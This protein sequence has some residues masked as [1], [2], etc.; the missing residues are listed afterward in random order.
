MIGCSNFLVQYAV[1]SLCYRFLPISIDA[2]RVQVA[3][4]CGFVISVLN[5]FYWNNRLVF[6]T[7][8]TKK[9]IVVSLF[10]TY[11]TYAFTGLLLNAALLYLEVDVLKISAYVA[12]FINLLITTPINFFMNKLWAFKDTSGMK[13]SSDNDAS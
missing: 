11:L 12:P 1:Y 7:V 5:A 8:K 9:D 3:N 13:K 2:T 6:K 10:K 4:I